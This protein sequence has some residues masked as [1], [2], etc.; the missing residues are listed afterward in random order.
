[1]LKESER[2]SLTI[3]NMDVSVYDTR[4]TFLSTGMI[5]SSPR[6]SRLLTPDRNGPLLTFHDWRMSLLFLSP[7]KIQTADRSACQQKVSSMTLLLDLACAILVHSPDCRSGASASKG[8]PG[9]LIPGGCV[10]LPGARQ[11]TNTL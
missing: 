2:G 6:T 4:D 3:D 9:W 11:N 1:M 7:G 8:T 10:L 5:C